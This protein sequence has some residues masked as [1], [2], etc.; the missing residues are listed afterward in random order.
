MATTDT[1][2]IEKHVVLRASRAKVWRAISDAQQ[3]GAWFGC[4]LDGPF[5]PGKVVRGKITSPGYDHLT[6][7]FEI[8]AIEPETYFA[9]R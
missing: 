3:F 5:A 9:Y 8:V 1:N 4:K 2:T 7:D 6:I